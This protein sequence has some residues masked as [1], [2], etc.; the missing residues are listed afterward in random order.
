[1]RLFKWLFKKKPRRFDLICDNCGVQ[2]KGSYYKE[3]NQ[4]KGLGAFCCRL[5]LS[6]D[7]AKKKS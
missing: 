1:M 4:R 3:L 6:E 5:C 2:F 7:K